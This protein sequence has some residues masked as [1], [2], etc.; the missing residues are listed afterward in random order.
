MNRTALL[1][2]TALVIVG[3]SGC[4]PPFNPG[5]T[6]NTSGTPNLTVKV[7][8][9]DYRGAHGAAVKAKGASRVIDPQTKW[10]VLTLTDQD[11]NPSTLPP[12]S[13]D[14]AS[15]TP[16]TERPTPV[17]M[18]QV[19]GSF[20]AN[21]G[22]YKSI[23]IEFR[24][25][26]EVPLTRGGV[27]NT[28][29]NAGVTN[30]VNIFCRPAAYQTPVFG[31]Q[32]SDTVAL[33]SMRYY[34]F[35]VKAKVPV[36]ISLDVVSGGSADLYVFNPSGEI[37]DAVYGVG[38]P[39][40]ATETF[41]TSDMAYVGVYGYLASNYGFKVT[42]W[43]V[44]IT[45]PPDNGTVSA[46]SGQYIF[47]GTY[48]G[49]M[50]YVAL[51]IDSADPVDATMNG[52]T[53]Q[54]TVQTAGMTNGS[55]LMRAV[56]TD[57]PIVP[58]TEPARYV[59]TDYMSFNV[60]DGVNPSGY[61]VSGTVSKDTS[62]G[63]VSASTPM[64]VYA[65]QN[66]NPVNAVKVETD[67]FPYSFTL[68]GLAQ[69]VYQI[70]AFINFTG[71]QDSN[72]PG[73]ASAVEQTVT[74]TNSDVSG[75]NLNLTM[76]PVINS[77]SGTLYPP[78]GVDPGGKS[79]YVLVDNDTDGWS[80][81]ALAYG[82][83]PVGAASVQYTIS[84]FNQGN[85]Y[86]YGGVDMDNS[87]GAPTVG[88]L[89][90]NANNGNT[91]PIYGAVTGK[92]IQF[93]VKPDHPP[94]ARISTTIGHTIQ[95]A[96]RAWFGALGEY[97]G[98]A[99]SDPDTG[100]TLTFMWDFGDGA[101]EYGTPQSRKYNYGGTFTVTLAVT[102]K[103]GESSQAQWPL[104]V[105]APPSAPTNPNPPFGATAVFLAPTLIWTASADQNGDTVGY[106]LYLSTT[107]ADP[108]PSDSKQNTNLLQSASYQ[109][110]V[111][112]YLASGVKYYWQVVADDGKGGR[113]PGPVWNFTADNPPSVNV[114]SHSNGANVTQNKLTVSGTAS[115]PDGIPD[116][117]YVQVWIQDLNYNTI[118]PPEPVQAIPNSSG[119]WTTQTPL[120]IK[121][122]S[123]GDYYL[124]VMVSDKVSL[125]AFAYVRIT[126]ALGTGELII[127]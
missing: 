65:V 59:A 96:D 75:I 2:M 77:V 105:N 42:P 101:V 98:Q 102:D 50:S 13:V 34:A 22:F 38:N 26:N 52:G 100:D 97:G 120:D 80:Y 32:L 41:N 88:D 85:Y 5:V 51:G 114:T 122:L 60:T 27:L 15:M 1:L 33:N 4:V 57:A 64:Y 83:W 76:N 7:L 116:L 23:D 123:N 95:L 70:G 103:Y 37:K 54:Y 124:T 69:G 79:Y 71:A 9:P 66:H 48:A 8:M 111:P 67:S 20:Y 35:Q 56:G 106:D 126:V 62:V 39:V 14:A 36:D 6:A 45:D 21:S 18:V 25:E 93:T 24:D 29:I 17:P 53:W 11:G 73:N 89:E 121:S 115:D 72:A 84:N 104:I 61:T 78:V 3:M 113:T 117:W 46:A 12:V 125:G 92:D 63:Y 10:M 81:V 58:N 99:S 107:Y 91:I 55:H 86:V 44:S 19:S 112:Q 108:L 40:S 47:R 16:Y 118:R 127:Q 90:G 110:P 31:Q 28:N 87:G 49:S 82:A 43:A 68:S 30:T 94:V 119:N 109:V 74:I